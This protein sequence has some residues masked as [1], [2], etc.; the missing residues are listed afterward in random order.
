[1]KWVSYSAGTCTLRF[2]S[3]VSKRPHSPRSVSPFGFKVAR[4]RA[5]KPTYLTHCRLRRENPR[6]WGR[7]PQGSSDEFSCNSAVSENTSDVYGVFQILGS[8]KWWVN[9]NRDLPCTE[10]Y[11]FF[12]RGEL[13][14]HLLYVCSTGLLCETPHTL[15]TVPSR[16]D[17]GGHH[18]F[19]DLIQI[20]TLLFFSPINPRN[21]TRNI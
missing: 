14:F 10:K 2:E 16:A 9:I 8:V 11:C 6:E 4:F 12:A 17:K 1:M 15:C 7:M 5:I 20:M 21:I 19:E 13:H 3:S 18:G